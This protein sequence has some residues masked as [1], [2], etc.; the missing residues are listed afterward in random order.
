[1]RTPQRMATMV[2]GEGARAAVPQAEASWSSSEWSEEGMIPRLP[3]AEAS[4]MEGVIPRLPEMGKAMGIPQRMA[5]L[6]QEAGARAAAVPE[7]EESWSEEE[8]ASP[9]Q[10]SP[11]LEAVAGDDVEK[12]REEMKADGD[13]SKALLEASKREALGV[14]VFLLSS[15]VDANS[16]DEQGRTAFS[17]AAGMNRVAA[18][19]LLLAFGADYEARDENGLSALAMACMK[20]R[21]EAARLCLRVWRRVGRGEHPLP[22]E[23]VQRIREM[24][25]SVADSFGKSRYSAVVWSNKSMREAGLLFD[26]DDHRMD[27]LDRRECRERLRHHPEV[28]SAWANEEE[29]GGMTVASFDETSVEKNDNE[30][31]TVEQG[32]EEEGGLAREILQRALED[33]VALEGVL[34][35]EEAVIFEEDGGAINS[36]AADKREITTALHCVCDSVCIDIGITRMLIQHGADI[37][38]PVFN[39]HSAVSFALSAGNFDVTI[40]LV[41]RIGLIRSGD[42]RAASLISRDSFSTACGMGASRVVAS[43]LSKPYFQHL[44]LVDESDKSWEVTPMFAAISSRNYSCAWMMPRSGASS[45]VPS[46][47]QPSA[48]AGLP[49]AVLPIHLAIS[50]GDM[51]VI[52]CVLHFPHTVS[53]VLS[54]RDFARASGSNQ[55]ILS[56]LQ[57]LIPPSFR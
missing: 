35:M 13:G 56:L 38:Q 28:D 47:I 23:T 2:Q 57:S 44:P 40:A 12:V 7:A 50:S 22:R 27:P 53:N 20:S 31:L 8:D 55:A 1:M 48:V 24:A 37:F 5:T 14:M 4:W 33:A 10:W 36:G 29:D 46:R 43:I 26:C 18:M 54:A 51:D 21:V 32:E 49:P 52:K 25:R 39:G 19:R 11:L 17:Y 41:D 16:R 34:P 42:S 30:H 3:E 45:N 9:K 6:V 15:G